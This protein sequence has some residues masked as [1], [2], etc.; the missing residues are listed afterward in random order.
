MPEY[1]ERDKA[2]EEFDAWIDS[3]G[4]LPKGTSYY[5][6]CKGCIEE[7]P[8]ADVEPVRHGQWVSVDEYCG[9][10]HEFKC[11]ACGLSLFYDNYTRFCEYEYC[12]NCG[13]KM[14]ERDM[15]DE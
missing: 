15:T 2:L 6:E 13:A 1:I 10:A 7:V 5:Y 3:T 4:A 9:H 14:D 12:P 8:A 11:T